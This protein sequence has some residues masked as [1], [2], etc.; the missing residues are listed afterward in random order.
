MADRLFD[1]GAIDQTLAVAERMTRFDPCSEHAARLVMRAR[2]QA[3]D[4]DGVRHAWQRIEDAVA[5]GLDGKPAPA[6]RPPHKHL[7]ANPPPRPPPSG[8]A[9]LP[10]LRPPNHHTTPPPGTPFPR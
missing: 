10:P 5:R 4:D 6:T 2:W 8:P 1:A 3:G 9:P 7:T